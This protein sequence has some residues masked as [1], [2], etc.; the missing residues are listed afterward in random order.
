[1][2]YRDFKQARIKLL[3]HP[4]NMQSDSQNSRP[5]HEVMWF[6]PT[7]KPWSAMTAIRAQKRLAL[8]AA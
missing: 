1:L 2:G 6:T 7:G 4:R 3:G 5:E 8:Q